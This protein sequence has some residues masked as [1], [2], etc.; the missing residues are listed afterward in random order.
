MATIEEVAGAVAVFSKCDL[1]LLHCTTEYP[2][3]FGSVN[4]NAMLTLK[5][6]FGLPVGYS[7]HTCGIEIPI[8]AV[9]MGAEIVEKHFTLDRN[10]NGPD[11]KASLEP[12]ELKAM[13]SAIRNVEMAFGSGIKV[14][15]EVEKKNIS[16]ARKSIVAKAVIRK[17][18]VLCA[19]NMTV[20]RPGDGLSP[21][22]W[23][24]VIGRVADRDYAPGD[25][26]RL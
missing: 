23:D 4:L 19:D 22:M 25:Q 14:P 10:M 9:A 13:V 26:I 18:D 17:G 16:V 6:R 24:E 15:A 20:K 8:A 11:H 3:P 7:D 12:K 5:K 21:M 2:C 1:T